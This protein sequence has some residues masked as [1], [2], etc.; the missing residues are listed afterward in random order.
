MCPWMQRRNSFQFRSRCRVGED[1]PAKNCIKGRLKVEQ[2]SK[3][4]RNT[5]QLCSDAQQFWKMVRYS[6]WQK[7]EGRLNE[8]LRRLFAMLWLANQTKKNIMKWI[9]CHSQVIRTF[10]FRKENQYFSYFQS[11][12]T[13]SLA[14][15]ITS[16]HRLSTANRMEP[17]FIRLCAWMEK[18]LPVRKPVW[19]MQNFSRIFA[20]C[21]E[22]SHSLLSSKK[23]RLWFHLS[24]DELEAT[25]SLAHVKKTASRLP[26]KINRK[27]FLITW[28]EALDFSSN[29]LLRTSTW[30]NRNF[31]SISMSENEIC[32]WLPILTYCLHV[33]IE[34]L[35][36][37]V[38]VF[39]SNLNVCRKVVEH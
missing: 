12:R 17:A 1:S 37:R 22:F 3:G 30:V 34:S 9:S 27:V 33:F 20:H 16:R 19:Q 31:S 21:K 35:R 23:Y 11:E 14:L 13:R 26:R 2:C 36:V 6:A 24:S 18:N 7:A 10:N 38:L 15:I 25:P 29:L 39:T 4:M 8:H 32:P 5:E 28:S